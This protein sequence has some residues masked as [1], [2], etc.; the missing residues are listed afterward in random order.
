[1]L[2][3]Q[4]DE[5]VLQCGARTRDLKICYEVYG[6][7]NADCSNVILV[8]TW[9]GF[10]RPI[11]DW[12]IGGGKG[13][14]TRRYCVLAMHS[15]GAGHSASA[16]ND[17]QLAVAGEP[18]DITIY[19]QVRVQASVLQDLGIARLHTVVGYGSASCQALQWG[20]LFPPMGGQVRMGGQAGQILAKLEE[21]LRGQGDVESAARFY[22]QAAFA[23]CGHGSGGCDKAGTRLITS[24]VNTAPCDLISQLRTWRCADISANPLYGGRLSAA[25]RCIRAPTLLISSEGDLLGSPWDDG[26]LWRGISTVQARTLYSDWGHAAMGPSAPEEDLGTLNTLL[27]GFLQ[28]RHRRPVLARMLAQAFM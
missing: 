27:T 19:D 9:F 1:M 15:L 6:T 22:A 21:I 2:T 26:G 28:A 23:P 14:D 13:L 10:G 3:H 24:I 25:L 12:V 17:P 20:C 18:L 5:L 4:V 7:L 16:S 11:T 8:P